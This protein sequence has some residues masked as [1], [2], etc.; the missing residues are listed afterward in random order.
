MKNKAR[1]AI[2]EMV[3]DQIIEHP[4]ISAI[5]RVLGTIY[6]SNWLS[7]GSTWYPVENTIAAQLSNGDKLRC[8]ILTDTSSIDAFNSRGPVSVDFIEGPTRFE[9]YRKDGWEIIKGANL[10]SIG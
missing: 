3:V 7:L 9:V 10:A 8:S 1:F 5:K 4:E 2:I 6:R